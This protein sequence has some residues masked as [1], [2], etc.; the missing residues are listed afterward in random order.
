ML[1]IRKILI[2]FVPTLVAVVPNELAN[3]RIAAEVRANTLAYGMRCG[4]RK[5][6]YMV[7]V[8]MVYVWPAVPR[9]RQFGCSTGRVRA[10]INEINSIEWDFC[11]KEEKNT[12][13][14]NRRKRNK[15]IATLDAFTELFCWANDDYYDVTV[16]GMHLSQS[17]LANIPHTQHKHKH[18]IHYL[19]F[20]PFWEKFPSTFLSPRIQCKCFCFCFRS[21]IR[22]HFTRAHLCFP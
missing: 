18:I 21:N 4:N 6:L 12:T 13:K 20:F 14:I 10:I 5:E 16:T 7:C 2:R 1:F 3:S 15:L 17:H 11:E 19:G 8:Q 22:L 9:N